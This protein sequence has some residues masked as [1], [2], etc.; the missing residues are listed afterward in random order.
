MGDPVSPL[1]L[2]WT[3]FKSSL[4]SSGGMGNAPIVHADLVVGGLATERQFSSALAIGQLS[5][6]PTGLWVVALGYALGGWLGAFAAFLAVSLPPLLTLGVA[7]L[8]RHADEHPAVEGLVWGLGV[9]VAGVSSGTML[10][11]V[12]SEGLRAIPL[13]IALG[14]LLLGLHGRAPVFLVI[15]AG[16]A[17]G[18]LGR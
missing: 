10:L 17:V 11:L 18:I 5:P 9:T 7:A 6:G 16:A 15:L 13:G 12:R 3:V 8:Y 14:A 1:G 2:F 4:L